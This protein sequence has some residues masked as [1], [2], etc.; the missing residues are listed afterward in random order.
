MIKPLLKKHI[1]KIALPLIGLI[2][3]LGIFGVVFGI[4]AGVFLDKLM[5]SLIQ[6]KQILR[7]YSRISPDSEY[8]DET[9]KLSAS[10]VVWA[11]YSF[12]GVPDEL[13]QYS[14]REMSAGI[15]VNA[16]H[17]LESL[18]HKF[19]DEQSLNIAGYFGNHADKSL[20]KTIVDHLGTAG[21]A[22]V[23]TRAPSVND[24]NMVLK[25]IRLAGLSKLI[26]ES[27]N[28]DKIEDDYLILGL[29]PDAGCTE[30]K[31]V[32]HRLA[33]EFHPDNSHGLTEAETELKTRAF[34]RIKEACDRLLEICDD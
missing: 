13:I 3:G 30:I 21:W 20:R 1:L 31:R 23:I 2:S 6:K 29:T 4:I 26:L 9:L 5:Y 33:T 14:T 10:Y 16:V 19:N 15:S 34:I 22:T 28:S 32:Y 24:S 11:I 7:Q 27:Q 25:I 8:D 12:S 17:N 18:K